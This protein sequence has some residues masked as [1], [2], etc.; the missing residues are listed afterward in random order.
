MKRF[1][2]VLI[3]ISLLITETVA[4]N[5]GS[6]IG[7]TVTPGDQRFT[8]RWTHPS[9]I[10]HTDINNFGYELKIGTSQIFLWGWTT[11]SI[12]SANPSYTVTGLDNGREYTYQIRAFHQPPGNSPAHNGPWSTVVVTPGIPA[13]TEVAPTEV[14]PAV[15]KRR[16]VIQKCPVGWVRSDGFAGRNRRVLLYEVNVEMDLQ[17]RVSIYKPVSVAIYVHP[18]EAL[19]NLDGWKLQVALP[20]NQ[21]REYLLTAENSVV[22][23][24]GFVEGG[25]AFIE[26]PEDNPFPMTE[27]GFT[28]APAPGFDYRLYDEIGRRVDFGISCYK[29]GDVFYVLKDTEN[30]RVLRKVP[31]EDIDWNASWLIRSEWT[32]PTPA[33]AAPTAPSLVKKSV[34]GTWADLKKQ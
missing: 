17:N 1:I 8:L 18:D 6:L 25:F 24:A 32:V 10:D 13:P 31:L 14:A 4:H 30:P 26:N 3:L 29:R 12:A 33:P 20:Y 9:I 22:V 5:P 2:P 27:I 11:A 15:R 16:R 23:D 21:H 28:G 19:E 34:V 7:L